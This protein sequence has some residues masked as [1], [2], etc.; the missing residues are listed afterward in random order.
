MINYDFNES[1]DKD[2]KQLISK[3]EESIKANS[4]QYFNENTLEQII[5]FYLEN[6][7]V[8]R[9]MIAVKSALELFPFSSLF[10]SK[11]AEI[12]IERKEYADAVEI[13][14]KAEIL[15]PSNIQLLLLKAD[16]YLSL[17]EHGEALKCIQ[18]AIDF[19]DKDELADLYLEMADIFEDWEKH[20]LV[21]EYL[22]KA[23]II[24]PTDEEAL[25]RLWFAIEIC[26]KYE[27]S[28]AFHHK[29]IDRVPYNLLAW[30]N[31][32]HAYIG[33]KK[34]DDAVESF[35]YAIAIDETFASSHSDCGD[36]LFKQ[37]RYRDAIPFYMDAVHF[38]K[39]SK[40]NFFNLAVCNEKIGEN[41]K[42]RYYYKKAVKIDPHFAEAFFRIG[43]N[44][45]TDARYNKAIASLEKAISLK[46]KN[47]NYMRV[48]GFMYTQVEDYTK[49]INIYEQL[50]K[51]EAGRKENWINLANV[52]FDSEMLE[53]CI[54]TL[55][56]GEEQF[57]NNSEFSYFKAA[58]LYVS[59]RKK[60]AL[61]NLEQGLA[62]NFDE[63][64]IIFEINPNF[65]N[66][67]DIRNVIDLYKN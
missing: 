56:R 49:A 37:K 4:P 24:R 53:D 39:G 43:Y 13:L 22:E 41:Q 28:I 1:T 59:G 34:F 52:Q 5:D 10:F 36:L 14:E 25:N 45:G 3:Y 38:S 21:I 18:L 62:K 64:Y 54:E 55:D 8:N 46:E 67:P 16:A 31:L 65:A 32:A 40:E 19:C 12:H 61:Y 57:E 7:H 27:H 58:I 23:L 60:E 33:M 42:A 6:A 17:S 44:Y 47:V 50:I 11:K 30:Y 51:L 20:D 63:H 9:A 26:E 66:D 48:L 2:L 29:L 15:D 35:K